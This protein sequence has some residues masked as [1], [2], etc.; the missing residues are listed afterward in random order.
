MT[1]FALVV[2]V[3]VALVC[4]LVSSTDP[5]WETSCIQT[6]FPYPF[7][8]IA[9]EQCKYD[10]L[11]FVNQTGKIACGAAD[12][13]TEAVCQRT[14]Y[15]GKFRSSQYEIS[16]TVTSYDNKKVPDSIVDDSYQTGI[17]VKGIFLSVKLLV[18]PDKPTDSIAVIAVSPVT[19]TLSL[20]VENLR[21]FDP[22]SNAKVAEVQLSFP[23]NSVAYDIAVPSNLIAPGKAW[24]I[25]LVSSFNSDGGRDMCFTDI[26]TYANSPETSPGFACSCLQD[27]TYGSF[28]AEHSSTDQRKWC[29]V[30]NDCFDALVSERTG[31]PY[32]NCDDY[33]LTSS[34]KD[35]VLVDSES[36][37]FYGTLRNLDNDESRLPAT[38]GFGYQGTKGL[39]LKALGKNRPIK[40]NTCSLSGSAAFSSTASVF[41]TQGES[42][43]D[44]L[45]CLD[46][47]LLTKQE[48]FTCGDKIAT[49]LEFFG[50]KAVWYYIW[51]GPDGAPFD[52]INPDMVLTGGI[53]DVSIDGAS[54]WLNILDPPT[55][56]EVVVEEP[57][58]YSPDTYEIV[59]GNCRKGYLLNVT[60]NVACGSLDPNCERYT[61]TCVDI[62]ECAESRCPRYSECTN[63]AGSFTCKCFPAYTDDG[64]GKCV[65]KPVSS[66]LEIKNQK[67]YADDIERIEEILGQEYAALEAEAARLSI[68]SNLEYL[69][70]IAAQKGPYWKARAEA[71]SYE[72]IEGDT[73]VPSFPTFPNI[74]FLG[75]GYDMFLGNPLSEKGVDPG[76]RL[77]IVEMKYTGG[78]SRDGGFSLPDLVDVT[79]E[80]YAHFESNV[81]VITSESEYQSTAT[82]GFKLNVEAGG[83]YEGAVFSVEGSASFSLNKEHQNTLQT[84]S[85]SDSVFV[86]IV[87]RSVVY[88]ARLEDKK[89]EKLSP[90]FMKYVENLDPS[91][92]YETGTFIPKCE[93]T[94]EQK[95][96]QVIELYGTHFTTEVVMGGKA[97]ERYTMSQ[98]EM[99]NIQSQMAST[100]VGFSAEV[101]AKYASVSGF[102]KTN[103]EISN[104]FSSSARSYMKKQNVDRKQWYLG[105]SPGLGDSDSGSLESIKRWA[106]TV[107]GNPVPV[108]CVISP[109]PVV[110]TSKQFPNDP[111]IDR[112][113]RHLFAVLY[114]ACNRKGGENC[115]QF[116]DRSAIDESDT[117]IARFGDFFEIISLSYSNLPANTQ[118]HLVQGA[119]VRAD[120]GSNFYPVNVATVTTDPVTQVVSIFGSDPVKVPR[121]ESTDLKCYCDVSETKS[122]LVY[123]FLVEESSGNSDADLTPTFYFEDAAGTV[124][125]ITTYKDN[126]DAL[127]TDGKNPRHADEYFPTTYGKITKLKLSLHLTSSIGDTVTL[128]NF[129][130][131][132][133]GQGYDFS[134]DISC[135]NGETC[136]KDLENPSVGG[137]PPYLCSALD[138]SLVGDSSS[139][140]ACKESCRVRAIATNGGPSCRYYSFYQN[141]DRC[142]LAEFL[143][144][145]YNINV[146]GYTG[147]VALQCFNTPPPDNIPL[148]YRSIAAGSYGVILFPAAN[149]VKFQFLS[150]F[151]T[152]NEARRPMLYGDT[153]FMSTA[154]GGLT[155]RSATSNLLSAEPLLDVDENN[156]VF[157]NDPAKL[158]YVTFRILSD[159]VPVG[160]PLRT[161]DEYVFFEI[162]SGFYSVIFNR[163][164]VVLL[165]VNP[166]SNR[167][168][169]VTVQS[170][171]DYIYTKFRLLPIKGK[172]LVPSREDLALILGEP[173][174]IINIVEVR[175]TWVWINA[176][177][178]DPVRRPDG[179]NLRSSDFSAN[180]TDVTTGANY[181]DCV[182]T[183]YQS[184]PI[185]RSANIFNLKVDCSPS[186]VI[187]NRQITVGVVGFSTGTFP[188]H[189]RP[190]TVP[191]ID[192]RPNV[193]VGRFL[194]ADD[195]TNNQLA[196]QIF[197]K[198]HIIT[199]DNKELANRATTAGGRYAITDS[200]GRNV[201]C[202]V[203]WDSPTGSILN[204][205]CPDVAE[206]EQENIVFTLLYP[207]SLRMVLP[208]STARLCDDAG[209][210]S[211][212]LP[213]TP[214]L[215]AITT[216]QGVP[217]TR[218]TIRD[219]LAKTTNGQTFTPLTAADFTIGGTY[220]NIAYNPCT[221]STACSNA[222]ASIDIAGVRS[223]T[224]TFAINDPCSSQLWSRTLTK[225]TPLCF[226][227]SLQNAFLSQTITLFQQA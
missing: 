143:G 191:V 53:F 171:S 51:I 226:N 178:S 9:L 206:G 11:T 56:S 50:R 224:T 126:D 195:T 181:A 176:T 20:F 19:R 215:T 180:V 220:Q 69:E 214:Y 86:Q 148:N 64:T 175:N 13:S 4:G 3:V 79:R 97:F 202:T 177:F 188:D 227:A 36:S 197:F 121:L 125:P 48:R 74:G 67:Q 101:S 77:S 47:G 28:C 117:T 65:E 100:T 108:S 153:F 85:K 222:L 115:G 186:V 203:S 43:C 128:K 92:E 211:L 61:R 210:Q 52:F 59:D 21:I 189:V 17:C 124:I 135:T 159:S 213:L 138:N 12:P 184:T 84:I 45:T 209:L 38:C 60:L 23:Y 88:R 30:A 33:S 166:D 165:G 173:Q 182:V 158:N 7:D 15:T 89:P 75:R 221:S 199:D 147:K 44:S 66:L 109:I 212:A 111:S 151:L 72:G 34:C 179:G 54:E 170:T 167:N 133:N 31:R 194:F 112:K 16:S 87:G 29:Y 154:N 26:A 103:G 201:D 168:V 169:P 81:K 35:A 196:G 160:E 193:Y 207:C 162:K 104:Q 94:E 130:V 32:K 40:I 76:Y 216:V 139:S 219:G 27:F 55:E 63:T 223:G 129:R 161:T 200:F 164:S 136:T 71:A 187:P 146:D 80:P 106:A 116:L 68:Q 185:E 83:S 107:T 93:D 183:A 62:D 218:I 217:S 144:I 70:K 25:E 49:K 78:I 96:Q 98:T 8:E 150:P 225:F 58:V 205:L 204:V 198:F 10:N 141:P 95:Y 149:Y 131:R 137:T 145:K 46:S 140:A 118:K 152:Y 99:T 120:D 157:Y 14:R 174:M 90:T 192:Y 127:D 113:R 5:S 39:W 105:G 142:I 18:T 163:L 132:F 57:F 82:S 37:R 134:G 24:I 91:C 2:A 110:L 155:T 1:R 172:D 41:T 123:S 6:D 119:V 114:N 208:T 122:V 190:V 42:I 102:L 73:L 156:K 22:I